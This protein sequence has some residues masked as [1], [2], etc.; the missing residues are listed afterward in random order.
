M[1]ATI[2]WAGASGKAYTYYIHPIGTS[3]RNE[4]GNYIY[5]KQT[6]PGFW[7]NQYTGQS[8]DLGRRLANHEKEACAKANGATHV[9]VHLNSGGE[10]ARR[11]EESDIISKWQPP[12]N[13]QGK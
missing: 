8:D 10:N 9:H 4:A 7:A 3:F 6:K 1:A 2:N 11:A 13:T 5:A 12:C